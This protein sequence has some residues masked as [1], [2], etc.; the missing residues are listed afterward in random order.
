MAKVKAKQ[1]YIQMTLAIREEISLGLA[2]GMKHAA[3]AQQWAIHCAPLAARLPA[4]VLPRSA[5][6]PTGRKHAPMM[7]PSVRG[8]GASFTTVRGGAKPTQRHPPRQS[9]RG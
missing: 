8:D 3:I 7:P 2:T 4:T 6:A 9:Y 1:S 5:I